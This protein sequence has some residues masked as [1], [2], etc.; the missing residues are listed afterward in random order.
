MEA[1]G[2]EKKRKM[3]AKNGAGENRFGVKMGDLRRLAKEIKSN[4]E[5][6]AELWKTGNVDAMFLATLLMQPKQL[7]AE[8]L[9]AMVASVTFTRLADWLG[10]NVVKLHPEKEAL[11]LKWMESSDIMCSRAGWSL[12]AE[13]IIKNPE[14]HGPSRPA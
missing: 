11:R 13:R 5:L 6:A 10:T 14:R 2:D 3:N 7:T 9:E 1:L 12:T 4:P 8:E